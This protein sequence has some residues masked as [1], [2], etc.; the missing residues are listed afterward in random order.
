VTVTKSN[1]ADLIKASS[2]AI[3][4]LREVKTANP[5]IE[6]DGLQEKIETVG[7]HIDYC[8]RFGGS[9]ARYKALMAKQ[10]ALISQREGPKKERV[11]RIAEAEKPV[12]EINEP[13]TTRFDG[14]GREVL[15]VAP[16]NNE[17]AEYVGAA[18]REVGAMNLRPLAEILQTIEK[19]E[20]TIQ[21]WKFEKS[22]KDFFLPSLNFQTT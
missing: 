20:T 8:Q 9:Q 5:P 14:W 1:M 16:Q 18:R 22:A 6:D 17:F 19:H 3:E 2:A 10:C 12:V 4:H 13:F 11:K 15:R 7:M 21:G